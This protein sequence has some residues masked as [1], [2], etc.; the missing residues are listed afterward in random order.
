MIKKLIVFVLV[1]VFAISVGV[2]SVGCDKEPLLIVYLGD[3][4]GEGIA[5]VS[6]VSERERYAYYG[7]LGIRNEYEFRNRAVSGHQTTDLLE[8]IRREDTDVKMIRTLLTDADIIHVSIL[9]NDLLLND[10]GKLI[11]T[12]ANNDYSALDAILDR[13]RANFAEIVTIL[14][15]YNPKATLMFQNVYNPVF[16]DCD[17]ISAGVRATLDGMDISESEYRSYGGIILDRLNDIISDYLEQNPGAYYII[18]A[19]AEFERIYQ[20]DPSR[21]ERLV[22]VD[23]IHPSNEGHAVIADLIQTKLESLKLAKQK[24]AVKNYKELRKEQ[25]QRL[26]GSSVDVGSV[27]A[28]IDSAKNCADI[29]KIYFEA[30][31]NHLPEY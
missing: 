22:F 2:V 7:I 26:Y 16:L 28:Q 27:S 4:I 5:G 1:A 15:G 23:S 9:G 3:S 13:S 12:V 19:R 21:G 31:Q 11:V 20:E 10:L 24:T 14:R 17:L 18:D 29:T 6:P 30:I 25:L 8:I